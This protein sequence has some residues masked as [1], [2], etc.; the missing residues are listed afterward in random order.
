M[1]GAEKVKLALDETRMLVLGIQ[2][3]LGFQMRSAFED[4]FEKLPGHTQA[5]DAIALMLMVLVVA[6]LI[7][8]AIHH[9]VV[10]QGEAAARTLRGISVAMELALLA[11]AISLGIN[12][13]MAIEQM[14]DVYWGTLA[15]VTAAGTALA[16]WFGL[17]WLAMQRGEGKPLKLKDE[18]IPLPKKIDQML[19]EARVILPGALALLGF[20]LAVVLTQ[21]FDQLPALSK[22]AHAV[23]LL[24]VALSTVL[25]M[26]PAAYHRIVYAGEASQR[27]LE[28]AGRFIVAATVALALGLAADVYVVTT[29]IAG[30]PSIGTIAA[31]LALAVL[32]GLWH[33]SPLVL[34]ASA[35]R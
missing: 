30:S 21:A 32:T 26:T 31:A 4:K 20:Q 8:P 12:I 3:L 19:T 34:R 5:L 13:F 10:D 23:A 25:L 11:F 29:K 7:A 6:L 17:E 27:F 33:V 14:W 35:R 1:D 9:R 16:F 24:M 22:A 18:Q 28:L 15:G 2:V